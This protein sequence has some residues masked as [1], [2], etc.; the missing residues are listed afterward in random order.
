MLRY[1][2]LIVGGLD[3]VAWLV[4]AYLMFLSGS[5][6]ATKGLDTAFGWA[7]SI[8]FAATALPGLILA[9]LGRA[10]R[11]ALLLVLAYPIA[12][13]CSLPAWRFRS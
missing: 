4:L 7:V 10:V 2:A 13:F 6:P 5:D 12:F 3:T 9:S 11:T 8:L 1:A